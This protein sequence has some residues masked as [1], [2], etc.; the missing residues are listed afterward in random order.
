LPR[1]GA[2]ARTS[3]FPVAGV[4]FWAST[5]PPYTGEPRVAP[6]ALLE[7]AR[8]EPSVTWV[9]SPVASARTQPTTVTR[10]GGGAGAWTLSSP[11]LPVAIQPRST[12]RE[13][14]DAVRNGVTMSTPE[15]PSRVW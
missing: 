5:K 9:L 12:S 7:I 1:S 10:P 2:S 13:V 4:S 11:A 15:A 14:P 8:V 3:R 6:I